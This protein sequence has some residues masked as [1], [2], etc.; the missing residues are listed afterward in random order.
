MGR[1]ILAKWNRDLALVEN[2]TL[3][4]YVFCSDVFACWFSRLC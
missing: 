1:N 2:D 4:E 3:F